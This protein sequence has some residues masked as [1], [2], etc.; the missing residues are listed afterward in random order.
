MLPELTQNKDQLENMV[1]RGTEQLTK[2]G[3]EINKFIEVHNI[4]IKGQPIEKS[5]PAVETESEA[6]RK[7]LLITN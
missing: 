3:Q 4:R 1:T 2:K 5:E 6:G 7:Q